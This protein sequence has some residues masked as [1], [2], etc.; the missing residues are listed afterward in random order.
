[1]L[2]IGILKAAFNIVV[3]NQIYRELNTVADG[4]LKKGLMAAPGSIHF[5]HWHNGVLQEEGF[6]PMRKMALW[7]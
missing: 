3:F 5:S 1:M 6:L 2:R 7:G 4:L